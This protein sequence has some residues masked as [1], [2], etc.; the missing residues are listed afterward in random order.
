MGKTIR[1][2]LWIIGLLMAAFP[3]WAGDTLKIHL[4]YAHKLDSTGHT[5]GRLVINQKI[6]TSEG[7]LFRETFFH[8]TTGQ[9]TGY[10]FYF[11]RNGRLYTSEF[12]SQADSLQYILKHDYDASGNAIGVT[13]YLPDR[14]RLN[15]AERII[16]NFGPDGKIRQQKKYYGK[17]AGEITRYTYSASG[18]LITEN[19]QVK[20]ISPLG[21]R[22]EIRSYSYSSEGNLTKTEIS[23]T[24]VSGK[25]FR[26]VETYSYDDQNRLT[27]TSIYN[28]LDELTG[29]RIY[30]YIAGNNLGLYEEQ[31]ALG[32]AI[33]L[34]EYEYKKHYMETG[35]Q[36]SR[37]ESF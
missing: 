7:I 26:T 1:N 27:A 24:D 8:E 13:R 6:H 34:Q 36:V 9:L 31:D 11:Y 3:A 23:T 29:K 33:V 28:E 12:Y 25:S 37:Y 4:T 15:P 32:K 16:R 17:K 21:Y 5:T 2:S 30:R 19:T 10:F 14:V 22:M 35:T 18:E 20:P